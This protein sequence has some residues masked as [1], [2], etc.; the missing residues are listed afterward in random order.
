MEITEKQKSV[1]LGALLRGKWILRELPSLLSMASEEG[2]CVTHRVP[3]GSGGKLLPW[4]WE[5]F[6]V[7]L[8]TGL[9]PG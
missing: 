2:H 9:A 6:H 4:C 5:D 3:S 1:G 7:T 8:E